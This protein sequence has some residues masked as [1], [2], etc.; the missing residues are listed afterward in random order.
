ML[1]IGIFTYSTRPRGSVVHALSL[2]E[3]LVR[4]GHDAT[5]YALAK[6]GTALYRPAAC[7]VVLLPAGAAPAE[8]DALVRQRVAEIAARAACFAGRHDVHHAQ[9]CLAA[10]ALLSLRGDGVA[11]VVRTVHHVEAFESPYLAA[12]QRRSVALADA[13]LTVSRRTQAE[14]EAHFGRASWLVP[15]GVDMG[16]FAARDGR[17]EDRVRRRL[18]IAPD[19]LVV[20]SVGGVEPRKDTLQALRAVAHAYA[21]TPRLRWIVVGDHSLWDHSDYVASFERERSRLP[22]ALSERIVLAGTVTEQDLT[23]LYGLSDVLLCTSQEEGFGL[24]VLEAMAAAT[25]VVAP[26][27]APFTEYL[28]D[29]CSLLVD[30]DDAASVGAGLSRLLLDPSRRAE[31]GEAGRERARS[32]AWDRSAEE[33]LTHYRSI[34]SAFERTLRTHERTSHA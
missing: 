27:R 9:D 22:A 20:L 19:D 24:C 6:P 10:S 12:C 29:G 8:A 13:V 31:V 2:A 25:P 28:D 23:A 4:A 33:H 21:Q 14:V 32:Y 16:R 30:A 5:L 1:S 17:A 7:P 18:R 26:R 15:N 3:A 11:P 34:R